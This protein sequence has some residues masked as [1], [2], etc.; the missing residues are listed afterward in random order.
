MPL[1][2]WTRSDLRIL[3]DAVEAEPVARAL[4]VAVVGHRPERVR[5][6][7]QGADAGLG[8]LGKRI[9]LEADIR[10]RGRQGLGQGNAGATNQWKK[11]EIDGIETSGSSPLWMRPTMS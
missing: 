5:P 9:G 2:T 1:W 4:H 7:H 11:A 8:A 3:V 10:L 6:G